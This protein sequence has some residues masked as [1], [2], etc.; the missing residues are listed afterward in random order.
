MAHA[1]TPGLRVASYA[2]VLRVRRLP[3]RGDVLARAGGALRAEDVVART[4]LPGNVHTV[5]VASLLG[6]PPDD[7]REAMLKKEGDNVA[8]D[9][10]I[11]QTKS[12]F[13]VFS[14]RCASPVAGTI[15]S[16][17]AVTGQAII[18]E[19]PM[20]VEVNAYVDG[21]VE[22]ILPGEGV[23]MRTEG[24]FVQGIFGIGGEACGE[25]RLACDAP[26]D[27]LTDARVTGDLA[28]KILV[29][30]SAVTHGAL[31]KAVG[32]R[33]RAVVAGSISASD[34]MAFLGY[35]IGVA[36][37][38]HEEKGITLI[39]TE[40]FGELAMAER[41]FALFARCAG[42]RASV[43][44][45]TQIRAGVMRPEII[46]PGAPAENARGEARSGPMSVGSAVRTIREP[47]F[48]RLG[49]V[50]ALPH[51]LREIETEARVRVVTVRLDDGA[52]ITLPRAN[53][54][55]VEE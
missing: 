44:G 24:A 33:A 22:S 41:T 35:D 26:R 54:E 40:G 5:K 12:F 39:I 21:V 47:W 4:A 17:S 37:T 7:I 30:G 42:M 38:G 20:P 50:T 29:G 1:Y 16:I 31:A 28:G 32:A 53:V 18:R 9:E 15:E 36:I 6:I 19:A 8:K 14:S 51:E 2:S 27:A 13:G 23:V 55:M 25:I 48:G 46:V 10:V 49:V 45:A 3:L 52:E 43:N 11:A 34:L